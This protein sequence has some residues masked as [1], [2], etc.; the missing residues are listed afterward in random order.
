[1]SVFLC[2]PAFGQ[3]NTSFTTGSLVSTTRFLAE[4]GQFYGFA[5][6]SFPDICDLR[7]IFLT[8]WFDGTDASHLLFVDHDMQFEPQLVLDMLAFDKPL[9]G[10]LYPKRTLPISWV[11]SALDGPQEVENGFMKVEGVGFGVTLIR[12][13]CVEAMIAGGHTEVDE[14]LDDCVAGR[15]L[16]RQGF[17]RMIRAFEKVR[18]PGR[19]LSED[20]SFCHRHRQAGGDVWAAIH[21]KVT[22]IGDFGYTGRFADSI[23]NGSFKLVQEPV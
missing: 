3:V 14:Y 5:Q 4:R 22:H 7:A 17:K 1:M 2:L 11:G 20:F 15:E 16:K 10:T 9:V 21:H 8:T 6:K 23:D 12:R 19:R 18:L 13:D